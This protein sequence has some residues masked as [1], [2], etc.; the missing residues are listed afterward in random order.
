MAQLI[1]DLRE[2]SRAARTD[3]PMEPTDCRGVLEKALANL[4]VSIRESG[5]VVRHDGLPTV[6]GDP[7]QLTQLFQNLIGNAVKFR[8]TERAEVHVSAV[9]RGGEWLFLGPDHGIGIPPEH[10]E[11]IF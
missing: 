2:F 4:A 9:R 8:G 11:R 7:T 10:A 3:R 5:A 1:D 6:Q